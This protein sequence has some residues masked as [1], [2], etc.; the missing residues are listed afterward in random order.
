MCL[1]IEFMQKQEKN[2]NNIK[3]TFNLGSFHF[4]I[5]SH[6]QNKTKV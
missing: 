1:L 3:S 2:Y 4:K 6:S 5:Q